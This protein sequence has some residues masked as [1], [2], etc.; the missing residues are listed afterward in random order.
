MIMMVQIIPY[1]REAGKTGV[2][3]EQEREKERVRETD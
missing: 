2:G 1:E 3:R